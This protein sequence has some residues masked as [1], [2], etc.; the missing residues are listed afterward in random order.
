MTDEA[1]IAITENDLLAFNEDKW[2]E[3][4]DGELSRI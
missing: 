1:K 2:I 3:V 4:V